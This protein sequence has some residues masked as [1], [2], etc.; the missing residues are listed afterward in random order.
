MP[1]IHENKILRIEAEKSEI[2]WLIIFTQKPYKEMSHVPLEVRQEIY[3]LLDKI[4]REML[5]YYK[6]EKINICSFG[7][8]LPIVHWHIMAR[9]KEDSFFPESMWGIK[10]REGNLSLPSYEFFCKSLVK[11]L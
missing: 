5:A 1:I 9:F 4:E 11:K 10:Q 6:P 7:N 3:A 2:P 8:Y